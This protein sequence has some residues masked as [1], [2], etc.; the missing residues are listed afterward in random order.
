MI[1]PFHIMPLSGNEPDIAHAPDAKLTRARP[2]DD[3]PL[4]R[5]GRCWQQVTMTPRGETVLHGVNVQ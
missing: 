4:C 5:A 1:L 2:D 3:C